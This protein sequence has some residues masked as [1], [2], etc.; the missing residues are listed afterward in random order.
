MNLSAAFIGKNASDDIASASFNWTRIDRLRVRTIPVH[1]KKYVKNRDQTPARRE[2]CVATGATHQTRLPMRF[3][4]EH[5]GVF[6]THDVGFHHQQS[7]H[8]LVLNRK[9]V[10]IT[11]DLTWF[12]HCI[13]REFVSRNTLIIRVILQFGE[14]WY[15]LQAHSLSDGWRWSPG[16]G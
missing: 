1:T 11:I 13:V 16:G 9:C 14:S 4:A 12:T 3:S 2:M 15:D 6:I 7:E 5:T 8:G 10:F